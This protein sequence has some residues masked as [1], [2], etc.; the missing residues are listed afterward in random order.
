[1]RSEPR[2]FSRRSVSNPLITASTNDERRGADPHAADRHGG[3]EREERAQ[4][5]EEYRQ[6][7]EP[8]ADVARPEHAIKNRC[9]FSLIISIG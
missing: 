4:R 8:C 3:E 1:V 9:R 6:A 7:G 2:I 5:A